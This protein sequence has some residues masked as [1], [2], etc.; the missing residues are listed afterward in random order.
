MR[1]LSVIIGII[2]F[3]AACYGM[4]VLIDYLER[5]EMFFTAVRQDDLATIRTML[6]ED[7]TVD[8]RDGAG[9]TA[10]HIA[11]YKGTPKT[12]HFLLDRGADIHAR[13]KRGGTPLHWAA[14]KGGVDNV[15]ALL[16]R[17]A[18]IN[19]RDKSDATPLHWAVSGIGL[20]D[21]VR[22]VTVSYLLNNHADANLRDDTGKTALD[23]ARN[24]DD[25]V[26]IRLLSEVTD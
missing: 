1:I 10:L 8:M 16:E 14:I 26:M 2:L 9:Q 13:D 20:L 3:T 17:G 7:M 24:R 12:I 25:K 19:A 21:V 22:F 18:K 23:I 6:G 5:K 15:E 11:A 4:S